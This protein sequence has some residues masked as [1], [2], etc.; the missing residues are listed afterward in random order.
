[1][2]AVAKRKNWIHN[3]RS[4]EACREAVEWAK[5]H[6]SPQAAWDACE[7]GDWM[8]W[9][10]G[11]LAGPSESDSRRKLVLTACKCARLSLK[12][13]KAGDDRPRKAIE[14][15]EAWARKK[16]GVTL[17]DVRAAADAAAD[18]ACAAAYAAG[19]AY[20]AN[21]AADAAADAAYA[22]AYAA[23]AAYAAYAAC[24]ACAAADAAYAA[25]AQRQ[26]LKHCA[27]IVRRAYPKAPVMR[28]SK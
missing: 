26:T 22:A 23:G 2:T 28:K 1:M 27:A 3:L 16:K 13:V 15:A 14:T 5:Q 25:Y 10:L 11:S 8:L 17:D 18:A 9:A 7:R 12:H 21:G 4:L 20:A 6:K 19:A 24:A